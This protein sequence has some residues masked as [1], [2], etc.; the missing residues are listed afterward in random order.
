[1][2]EIP[3]APTLPDGWFYVVSSDP[4][5][6]PDW[7]LVSIYLTKRYWWVRTNRRVVSA[8]ACVRAN[9]LA[10]GAELAWKM[11]QKKV[12]RNTVVGDYR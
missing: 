1:M 3:G 2:R 8:D 7:Y 10:R 4:D 11:Y 6:D 5:K 9:D 12:E